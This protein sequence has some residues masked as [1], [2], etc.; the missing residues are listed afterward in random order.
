[1]KVC[2][3]AC[4]F[5]AYV[6]GSVANNNLQI[7]NCLDVGS[8]TGLLSLMFAQKNANA[9]IDA[10]EIE[11]NAFDQAKENF[12]I[13]K[14]NDRLNIFNTDVKHFVSKKKYDLIISN[15]PF[16]ENELLSKEK[17]KNIAKHDEGLTLKDLISI[18]RQY[19]S[20]TGCFAILLPYHRI[21]YFEDMAEENNL[22]LQQKLLIRQTPLH[23]FFRGILFWGNNKCDQQTNEFIIKNEEGNYSNEFI[24]LMKEYYLTL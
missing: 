22:F 17:N 16:Y 12:S 10:V 9:I 1:M 14:W 20:N 19:L 5:G 7:S 4:I 15:P 23:N 18:V 24:E 21:K 8:G 3:D 2:T 11:E 13:S 6:A